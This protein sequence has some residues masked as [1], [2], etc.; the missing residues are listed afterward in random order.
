MRFLRRAISGIALAAISLAL[1]GWSAVT[2]IDAMRE[3]AQI[4]EADPSGR[5]QVQTV[6]A[7][8]LDPGTHQAVITLPGELRARRSLELR[9]RASGLVVYAAPEVEEGGRV[10]A[11]QLLIRTD[12]AAAEAELARAAAD[13]REAQ[14]ELRDSETSAELAGLDLAA[15]ERQAGLQE[16][17]RLRQIDLAGRGVGSNSAVE[18]AELAAAAADQAVVSRQMAQAQAGTRIDQAAARLARAEVALSEARRALADTEIHAAFDGTLSE[19]TVVDGGLVAANERLAVLVDPGDLEVAFRVSTVQYTRLLGPDGGLAAGDVQVALDSGG[20]TLESGAQL[21]RAAAVVGESQTGRL[22]FAR[23]DDAAGFR[24]GDLV[25]VRV[26][27]LP[28]EGVVR[29]PS[30]AVTPDGRVMRIGE[31]GRLVDDPVIVLRRQG[32]EVLIRADG[33]EGAQVVEVVT[34]LT[35]PGLRVEALESGEPAE[36][37]QAE[38]MLRLDPARKARLIAYVQDSDVMT[39]DAKA[40]VLAQLEADEVPAQ[41]VETLESRMGS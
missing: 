38:M 28:L 11:G 19:V 1:L 24:S 30:R 3:A 31:D 15:A 10:T 6:R 17:A 16:A 39:E 20:L 40:R 33:L 34:P 26:N 5:E 23:L 41:M 12:P 29:L 7:L 36:T 13:L 22:L 37:L 2:M 35:G 9:A 25:R 18:T 27:E 14:Q 4:Q 32:D 8:T 21:D